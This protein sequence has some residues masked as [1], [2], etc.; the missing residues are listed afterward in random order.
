MIVVEFWLYKNILFKYYI[1]KNKEICAT[2]IIDLISY[3]II[4]G[5]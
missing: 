2:I 5:I 1:L 4:R 3:Y